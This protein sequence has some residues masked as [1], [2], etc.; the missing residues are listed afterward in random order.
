MDRIPTRFLTVLAA[1]LMLCAA[2][3]GRALAWSGQGHEL[4]GAI[5]ETLLQ[6]TRAGAEVRALLDGVRLADAAKWADC[7]KG[8]RRDDDDFSY[9]PAGGECAA[10]ETPAEIERMVDFA[11]RNWSNCDAGTRSCHS[12]YHSAAVAFQRDSYSRTFFGTSDTD[13]VQALGAALAVLQDRQAPQPFSIKDKKEAL[14]LL[15]QFIGDLHQPLHVGAIYLGPDGTVLD[16][17]AGTE[18]LAGRAALLALADTRGGKQIKFGF[19][20]LA[21]VWSQLPDN[22]RPKPGATDRDRTAGGSFVALARDVHPTPQPIE[23]LPALWAGETV[24]VSASVFDG[25]SFSARN[26]ARWTAT[27]D[28]VTA[29]KKSIPVLQEFQIEKAGARL[30]E[31]LKRLWP[32]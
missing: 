16:P 6:G 7:V 14:L 19:F 4:T 5:A 29:Y 3:A 24:R 22:W 20:D 1:L 32:E 8:V 11:R 30:A 23:A 10:F 25:M 21:A 18:D 12:T 31:V 27:A 28:N 17:D 9:K 13:I 15:A 2:P 26:G